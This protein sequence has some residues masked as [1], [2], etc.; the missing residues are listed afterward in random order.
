MKL[1]M[2]MNN[3]LQVVN[4]DEVLIVQLKNMRYKNI[5]FK[6]ST[7]KVNL[8]RRLVEKSFR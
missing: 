3:K 1:K 6:K 7:L 2:M 4:N 5:Y 8:T